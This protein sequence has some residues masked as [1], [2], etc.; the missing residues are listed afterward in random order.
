MNHPRLSSTKDSWL[1]AGL[2]TSRRGLR[3]TWYWLSDSLVCRWRQ[4]QATGGNSR[5]TTSQYVMLASK[6]RRGIELCR[7]QASLLP[8]IKSSTISIINRTKPS[9]VRPSFHFEPCP[10]SVSY[11]HLRAHETRHDLVCRLLL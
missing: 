1:S 4:K 7:S 11:T 3:L 6:L 9:G 2:R 10:R 8:V 5:S